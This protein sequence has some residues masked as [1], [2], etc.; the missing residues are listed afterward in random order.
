MFKKYRHRKTRLDEL[1]S[2]EIGWI[3]VK[4]YDGT[5]IKVDKIGTVISWHKHK[6][7]KN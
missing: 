2:K 7:E 1:K 4:Y 6:E 5:E 3:D